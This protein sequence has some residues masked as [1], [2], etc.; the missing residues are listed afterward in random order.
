M[1]LLYFYG[2]AK[3]K[4][5]FKVGSYIIYTNIFRVYFKKV[6]GLSGRLKIKKLVGVVQRG[7]N[8]LF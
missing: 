2:L 8:P 5:G 3:S 6:R 1:S 7:F 4:Y